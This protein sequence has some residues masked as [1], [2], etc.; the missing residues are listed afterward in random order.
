MSRSEFW[1]KL[2]RAKLARVSPR[3]D[4]QLTRVAA[5][6]SARLRLTDAERRLL[7]SGP[8]LQWIGASAH[9]RATELGTMPLEK[10]L[11]SPGHERHFLQDNADLIVG[12]V[13]AAGEHRAGY[14]L[15]SKCNQPAA[16][17]SR[18]LVNVVGHD[19][20]GQFLVDGRPPPPVKCLLLAAV[21]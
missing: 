13:C 4:S 21:S 2:A 7:S 17:L 14:L 15:S 10:L 3:S 16:R 5:D 11:G 19:E 6:P 20:E 8:E 12:T 1:V 9:A 18:L